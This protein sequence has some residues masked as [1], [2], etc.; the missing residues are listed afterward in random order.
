[1]I[2]ECLRARLPERGCLVADF[3]LPAIADGARVVA[4][5]YAGGFTDIGSV[6]EYRAANFA[7]LAARGEDA[8]VAASARVAAGVRVSRSVVGEGAR[9]EGAGELSGC[10]VWPGASAFAPLADE[11]VTR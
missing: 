4:F 2:G 6:G 8:W 9:V 7:W 5:P 11:V 1:M 3:Y 10:V